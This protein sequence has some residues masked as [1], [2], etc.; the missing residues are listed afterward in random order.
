MKKWNRWIW[1]VGLLIG[2]LA[3]IAGGCGDDDD[4]DDNDDD[5]ADDDDSTDD[6]DDDDDVPPFEKV[7]FEWLMI[8]GAVAPPNPV[9]GTATPP[10]Y[11]QVPMFRCR[12]DTGNDPPRAVKSVL[13]LLSGASA[14][15]TDFVYMA[16]DLVTMAQGE[17]EVWAPDRRTHLLEDQTGWDAAE[18]AKDPR[19]AWNYYFE[20]AQVQGQT[21]AGYVQSDSPQGEMAAE[22]GIDLYMEN[23]HKLVEKVE[24]EHRATNI[25]MGG[26]S[27]GAGFAQMYAAYE[28]SDGHKG[29]DD[30][31]GILLIDGGRARFNVNTTEEEYLQIVDEIRTGIRPRFNNTWGGDPS[32]FDTLAFYAMCATPDYTDPQDPE[33]GPDGVL[34]DWGL[35]ELI[36]PVITRGRKVTLT[37]EAFLALILDNASGLVGAF[38]GHLG[39]LAGGEVGNDFL[40]DFPKQNGASYYWKSYT[41]SDPEELMD[42]QRMLHLTFEGPSDYGDPYYANRFQEDDLCAGTL[43]AE[44]TWREDYLPFYSNRADMPVY[45]L[46]GELTNGTG[47]FEA[48]NAVLPA[49]RGSALPRNEFEFRIFPVPTWG[50]IDVILVAPDRNPFYVDF[51]A[52]MDMWS[53]GW[54]QIPAFGTSM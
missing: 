22:W 12:Q 36:R 11:N 29:S 15:P 32:F 19:I 52:W 2:L 14:G 3:V 35:F 28:F 47:F 44:G 23:V 33:M 48:Y 1:L 21:F 40:G 30:L 50:H 31:A 27:R 51:L 24:Q 37:N 4:D 49:V 39:E 53:E 7:V 25:F 45:A 17:I 16:Q 10:E 38:F 5:A 6:D 42:L 8:D 18:A 34:S 9:T 41:E 43:L 13:I 26:H 20:G 54:I 46:A